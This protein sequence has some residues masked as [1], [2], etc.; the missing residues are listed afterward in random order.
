MLLDFWYSERCTRQIKL[1]VCIVTC[2]IVYY[3]AEIQKLSTLFAVLCLALGLVT[4]VLY[5]HTHR[6]GKDHPYAQGFKL[7]SSMMPVCLLVV[8][9]L[10]LPT[11]QLLYTALQCIGFTAIGLFLV[12]IYES[13]SRRYDFHP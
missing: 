1:M 10:M 13:R 5:Q 6:L 3:C 8:I 9:I 12:S 4:H 11:E 7:L 2:A